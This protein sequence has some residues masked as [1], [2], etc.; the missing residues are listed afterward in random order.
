MLLFVIGLIG[1]TGKIE[2]ISTTI[3]TT[4]S[5]TEIK[6]L[7]ESIEAGTSGIEFDYDTKIKI[8]TFIQSQIDSLNETDMSFEEK[9]NLADD[10][11]KEAETKF[12]I[13]ESDIMLIM[14]DVELIEE[15]YLNLE[16]D[17]ILKSSTDDKVV[18]ARFRGSELTN[19]QY[20]VDKGFQDIV[21]F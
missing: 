5:N 7:I 2:S 17:G 14:S 11:W 15:Y 19:Y 9:E 16:A 8:F 10:V 4:E 1:C 20:N 12:N 13:T 21:D 18:V 3:P 6:D